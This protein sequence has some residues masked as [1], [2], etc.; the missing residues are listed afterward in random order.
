M[1][2]SKLCVQPDTGLPGPTVP[3]LL[4]LHTSCIIIVL[5]E[6][7]ELRNAEAGIVETSLPAFSQDDPCLLLV[8]STDR[9]S[10][11]P[12]ALLRYLPD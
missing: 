11:R 6:M 9:N 2:M 7:T 8:T 5:K 12:W 4:L 3:R 10:V 1:L